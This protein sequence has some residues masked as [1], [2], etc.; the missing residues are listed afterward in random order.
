MKRLWMSLAL[1]SLASITWAQHA[2]KLEF[3]VESDQVIHGQQKQADLWPMLQAHRVPDA[4]TGR[5]V[6][7]INDIDKQ[8]LDTHLDDPET[9]RIIGMELPLD[10]EVDLAD[11]L[12]HWADKRLDSGV[13][14]FAVGQDGMGIWTTSLQA[15]G[16]TALRLELSQFS[17]PPGV[18][19]YLYNDAQQAHGPYTGKGPHDNGRFWT[20]TVFGDHVWI[21]LHIDNVDTTKLERVRFEISQVGH[22]GERFGLAKRVADKA[23]CS[24]NLSCV[25]NAECYGWDDILSSARRAVARTII[26][27]GNGYI[28]YCSGGLLNDT[29]SSSQ[30]AWFLTAEHCVDEGDISS[31][32]S[33]FQYQSPCGSCN[34]SSVDSVIG[35]SIRVAGTDADFALL[36]LSGLPSGGRLMGWSNGNVESQI[37]TNLYRISHPQGQPQALSQHMVEDHNSSK[38]IYARTVLGTTEGG[39]SG[40]PIFKDDRKVVGVYSGV[41]NGSSRCDY[42]TFR[43]ADGALSYFWPTVA[44]FLHPGQGTYSLHVSDVTA[45][46]QTVNIGFGIKLYWP[47]VTVKVVNSLGHG[48]P[49]VTVQGTFSGGLS[50][51]YSLVTNTQGV[52]TFLHP[53]ISPSSPSFT[54]CVGDL[55]HS[56]FNNYDSGANDVTC[57][58]R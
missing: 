24:A 2:P 15:E 32:E 14:R 52:A 44:P 33:F 22:L 17:L 19:L 39:S 25:E 5:H 42:T 20:H 8:W 40:A 26:N 43:T 46:F 54:F 53:Q 21:Q 51:S 7:R 47:K 28:S 49:A 56:Y 30:K 50:G 9:E 4:E 3:S 55:T 38:Y 12:M 41:T 18:A 36:E 37:G 27:L 11:E 29:D 34:A 35:A 23:D 48:I 10:L 16:A 13:G 58:S 31:L 57:A 1:F 6:A 45:G